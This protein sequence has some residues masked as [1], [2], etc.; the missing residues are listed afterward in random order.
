MINAQ[1]DLYILA[2]SPNQI[3]VLIDT[4]KETL[5]PSS[6]LVVSDSIDNQLIKLFKSYIDNSRSDFTRFRFVNIDIVNSKLT[7]SYMIIVGSLSFIETDTSNRY[8]LLENI[9]NE[10]NQKVVQKIKN[11]I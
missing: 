11:I 5:I 3:S 9:A 4:D 2:L 7:I 6:D 1:L 8:I 10:Y